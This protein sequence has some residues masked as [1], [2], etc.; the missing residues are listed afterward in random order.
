SRLSAMM[1][2]LCRRDKTAI[3]VSAA[4]MASRNIW[5]IRAPRGATFAMDGSIRLRAATSRVTRCWPS[6]PALKPD[7]QCRHPGLRRFACNDDRCDRGSLI[8]QYGCAVNIVD[9]I[10]FQCRVNADQPAICAPGTNLEA[11]T[12]A[13][14]EFMLNALTRAVLALGFQRGQVVGVLIGNKILHVALTLAL[15][16]IGVVTVSCRGRTLP[17]ELGA[18]AAITEAPG[19]FDNVDRVVLVDRSWARGNGAPLDN[20]QFV[21]SGDELCR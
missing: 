14:L 3:C 17:K 1:S 16:R 18:V 11:M 9:P 7:S 2:A 10:L 4:T 13:Q 21:T 19:P 20:A 8:Y 12:Y 6:P 15:A 5:T